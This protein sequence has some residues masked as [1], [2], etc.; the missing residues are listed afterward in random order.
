MTSEK[1]ELLLSSSDLPHAKGGFDVK[2]LFTTFLPI[3]MEE[4]KLYR[5]TSIRTFLKL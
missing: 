1:D 3:L 2:T 5:P 4:D